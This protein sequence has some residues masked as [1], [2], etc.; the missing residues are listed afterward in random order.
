METVKDSY[1]Y[2]ENAKEILKTKAILKDKF[3]EDPKYVRM[4]CNTAYSGLLIAVNDLFE[5]KNIKNSKNKSERSQATDVKFYVKNLAQINKK[6]MKEFNEAYK[7]LHLLGG[8]DGSLYVDTSKNGI[9]FAKSL[10]TWI[11]K[12]IKR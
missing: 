9:M 2:L 5:Y 11:D 3:Y 7:Y 4:A 1:R 10:I 12:Q 6:K 8:Y